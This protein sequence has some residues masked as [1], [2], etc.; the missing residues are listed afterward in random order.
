MSVMLS[1]I[2]PVYNV[3]AYLEKCVWS[4]INQTYKDL[5]IILIN[6]GSTDDSLSKC[7][8]LAEKDSRILLINQNNYGLSVARNTG[9]NH[10]SGEY[11]FFLDSDDWLFDSSSIAIMMDSF[12]NHEVEIAIG[13][14]K[15]SNSDEVSILTNFKE[16]MHTA[17]CFSACNKIF[18]KS[19]FNNYRFTSGR[20]NEDVDLISRFLFNNKIVFVSKITYVY[21]QR[22]GSI[23]HIFNEK[24]FD[25]IK[26]C[27]S[28]LKMLKESS[29]AKDSIL[30]A[31][32]NI[33]AYQLFSLCISI[34]FLGVRNI[35]VMLRMFDQ[36]LRNEELYDEFY[37]NIFKCLFVIEKR[38]FKLLKKLLYLGFLKCLKVF[39]K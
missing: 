20:I 2:I 10:S 29:L 25:M 8:I 13:Q 37:C 1:V 12:I 33:I 38:R 39:V 16:Y 36:H 18:K 3:S 35:I 11:V 34:G 9:L 17:T 21:Y 22:E 32:S 7:K 19:I 30:V 31:Y 6:D 28:A 14:F 23:Q 5:E 15:L 27:S 24:R 4:V 26:S